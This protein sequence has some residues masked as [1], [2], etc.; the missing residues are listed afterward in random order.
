MT[1]RVHYHASE[2][3]AVFRPSHQKL[4]S[5]M[6]NSRHLTD[7]W[8]LFLKKNSFKAS[9]L[10]IMKDSVTSVSSVCQHGRGLLSGREFRAPGTA[11]QGAAGAA[12]ATDSRSLRLRRGLSRRCQ[13]E[14]L[15]VRT[16]KQE[17]LSLLLF[18]WPLKLISHTRPRSP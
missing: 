6:E 3:T 14:R 5:P 4:H 17:E 8:T 18:F 11:W 13:I 16:E 12:P 15:A 10:F 7:A 2:N 1:S 9:W